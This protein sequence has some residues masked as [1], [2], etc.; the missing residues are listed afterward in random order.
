MLSPDPSPRSGYW[1]KGSQK[2]VPSI[3]FSHM[4][5]LKGAFLKWMDLKPCQ[6]YMLL[7]SSTLVQMLP[8]LSSQHGGGR[9]SEEMNKT[10]LP[11][12]SPPPQ[13]GP[14]DEVR[15]PET[16]FS[17]RVPKGNCHAPGMAAQ[18]VVTRTLLLSY[19]WD[20]PDSA[21]TLLRFPCP[22]PSTKAPL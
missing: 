15:L 8:A 5:L 9:Q 11:E 10:G 3:R 21:G 19:S 18:Y 4:L 17:L 2:R 14:G 7:F 6:H 13:E 16:D 1:W 22:A 20:P 12:C